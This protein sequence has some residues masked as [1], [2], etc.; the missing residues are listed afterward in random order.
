MLVWRI[1]LLETRFKAAQGRRDLRDFGPPRAS[2]GANGR[3]A[4][5]WKVCGRLNYECSIDA[6]ILKR[7][8]S[9][10]QFYVR[11]TRFAR[12]IE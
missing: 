12:M 7:C 2:W 10:V 8:T 1:L 4:V 11:L 3:A 6:N 9:D 5:H